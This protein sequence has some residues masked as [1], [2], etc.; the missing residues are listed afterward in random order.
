MTEI[1]F[2]CTVKDYMRFN[3]LNAWENTQRGILFLLI[4]PVLTGLYVAM[5]PFNWT[6]FI[7]GWSLSTLVLIALF[8]L[9][10]YFSG[11][12][13]LQ[14][15]IMAEPKL[16]EKN[17][18]Q[19]SDEGIS[20]TT[21]DQTIKWDGITAVQ[22]NSEFVWLTYADKTL[23]LIP[24][25]V[26]SS[27]AERI[28]FVGFTQKAINNASGRYPFKTTVKPPY[29]LGLLCLIPLIGAIAGMIFIFLGMAKYKDKWFTLIGVAG[30][31]ITV[32]VYSSIFYFTKHSPVV[33]EG[34]EKHAQTQLNNLVSKVEFYKTENGY[35]PDSLQQLTKS[36]DHVW[37]H[38]PVQINQN[39][40]ENLFFYQR[41]S[42]QYQLFSKGKDG[43][44]YTGDD[45]FPQ[46]SEKAVDQ[47]GLT[48]FKVVADSAKNKTTE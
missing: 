32:A 22:S 48:T 19:I 26:F 4:L 29:A 24:V 21:S 30:I 28:N 43:K 17:K 8:F 6:T 9:F 33:R 25:S 3:W 11:R 42:S 39:R 5:N 47:I 34:F 7:I 2:Q 20:S 35:Y 38:D 23:S 1:E 45:L 36:K 13:R 31:F 40:A 10:P 15:S 18:W 27:P 41:D 46:V 12:N 37:I 44:P 14:K 16:L